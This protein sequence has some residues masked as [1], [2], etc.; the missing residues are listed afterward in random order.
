MSD[1]F[2]EISEKPL[3][4]SKEKLEYRACWES[5]YDLKKFLVSV[6]SSKKA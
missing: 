3:N 5:F 2:R 4:E 1:S 6:E